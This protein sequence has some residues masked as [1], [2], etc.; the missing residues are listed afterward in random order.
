MTAVRVE[1]LDPVAIR[2]ALTPTAARA[3]TSLAVEPV[4]ASTNDSL[5]ASPAPAPGRLVALLAEQ[6]TQGRGRRGRNWISPAGTG[7]CL[8]VAWTFANSPEGI[9]ALSLAAG[10]A[11]HRAIGAFG[12]RGV[13]LKWPNDVVCD[14]G[15]VAG[16]LVD[17]ASESGGL[18]VVIGV[19]LNLTV[20]EELALQLPAHGGMAPA[21]LDKVCG[22]HP[23]SRNAV[24]AA[25]ISELH[26]I[27]C[28]FESGGFAKLAD[29]WR[30]Y[31]ALVGRE[32]SVANGAGEKS[33]VS[34]GIDDSGALLL[35]SDGDVI[36][37]VAGDVTVRP[38]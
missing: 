23:V 6:Q 5:C 13:K 1:A 22:R 12:A 34:R 3:V 29:R 30:A 19:G 14:S 24:A 9:A 10:L 16:V 38:R 25:V 32:I 15:K 8:S 2:S 7:L 33:G 4:I 27:L 36:A 37:V 21:G 17:A 11:V 26:R 28:E 35:E 31:D 18:R 20:S